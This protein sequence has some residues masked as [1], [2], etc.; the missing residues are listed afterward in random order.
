MR[1]M[2]NHTKKY[3]NK[4]FPNRKQSFYLWFNPIAEKKQERKLKSK[5]KEKMGKELP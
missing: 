3:I 2:K 5:Q 4:P 1:I